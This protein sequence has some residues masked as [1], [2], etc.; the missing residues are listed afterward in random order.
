MSWESSGKDK[1]V[2]EQS[3]IPTPPLPRLTLSCRITPTTEVCRQNPIEQSTW[4]IWETEG[5]KLDNQETGRSSQRIRKN[6]ERTQVLEAKEGHSVRQKQFTALISRELNTNEKFN[7]PTT[8]VDKKV[9]DSASQNLWVT[10]N[11]VASFQRF[12]SGRLGGYRK[13]N[14]GYSWKALSNK[15]RKGE[16]SLRKKETRVHSPN[17]CCMPTMCQK[18]PA[19]RNA[20]VHKTQS[21][22]QEVYDA[23][24]RRFILFV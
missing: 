23:I 5:R 6:L 20:R 12:A 17:I 22:P 24:R 14:I 2:K 15:E 10:S 11:N 9:L 19:A 1:V 21:C 13:V 18:W 4:T 3:Q 8:Q 16:S 7:Q